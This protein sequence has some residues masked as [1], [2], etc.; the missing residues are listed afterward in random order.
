MYSVLCIVCIAYKLKNPPN[1]QRAQRMACTCL[2]QG[3]YIPWPGVPAA[4]AWRA[5]RTSNAQPANDSDHMTQTIISQR[6]DFYHSV[7]TKKNAGTWSRSR[8]T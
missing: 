5:M 8:A 1:E 2:V 6:T 7:T 4:R 3:I